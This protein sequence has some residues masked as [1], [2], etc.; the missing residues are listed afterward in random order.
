[1]TDADRKLLDDAGW[2]VVCESPLEIED[3][4]G[5]RA[6]LL[7]AE[8]VVD[9]LKLTPWMPRNNNSIVVNVDW[10]IETAQNTTG[11]GVWVELFNQ[12][13]QRHLEQST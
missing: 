13:K 5:S 3:V 9:W 4:D 2:T 8:I 10:L 7:A 6:T 11:A 12:I 1:M